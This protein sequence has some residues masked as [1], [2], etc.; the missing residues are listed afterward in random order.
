M[1]T[2]TLD[3]SAIFNYTPVLLRGIFLTIELTL[4]G[5]LGGFVVGVLCAWALTNAPPRA[6]YPF[7]AYVEF[8][9]NTPF[10]VQ[11]FFLFFGLPS[12]GIRLSG[13]HASCLAIILNTG[14]YN[15]EI[16]RAGID[17][18]SKGQIEAA[19]S[20]GLTRVLIFFH[21]VLVPALKRV[22]PALA[23]Q[24]VLMMLDSSV[25]SQ[26]SVE[27]LTF[28]GSF[29]QSRN[30]RSFET[31]LIITCIYF[32]LSY[33]ARRFLLKSDEWLLVRRKVTHG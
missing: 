9:R 10:L 7:V 18:T 5:A 13:F 28:A 22:W 31:Y 27:E 4:V 30:F 15:S 33:I 2:I 25:C 11:L 8:V 12:L 14:A 3:F 19:A 16:M 21:V 6:R 26:V 32:I 17:A 20:L 1:A 24:V 23:S 29:I